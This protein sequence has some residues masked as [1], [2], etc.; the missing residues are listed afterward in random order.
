MNFA[1]LTKDEQIVAKFISEIF[2]EH[3]QNMVGTMVWMN[4][5]TN[6]IASKRP[7]IHRVMKNLTTKQ[8]NRIIA[9]IL[10]PF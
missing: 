3:N 5:H 7:D 9:E 1:N 4:N 8:F 2:E 10:L 6:H